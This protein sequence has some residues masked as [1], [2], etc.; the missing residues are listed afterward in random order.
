MGIS[1]QGRTGWASVPNAIG[2][3]RLP[4]PT[5]HLLLNLLTHS[6]GFDASY[7]ILT[8]QTG[9]GRATISSA[10]KN[11][12]KL[13]LVSVEKKPGKHGQFDS[14]NYVFHAD[15]LWTLTP[16][17]VDERLRKESTGS[18][19]ELGTGS[20][21]ELAPVQEL[22][23][24]KEQV[25]RPV[26][27]DQ[28]PS[29]HSDANASGESPDDDPDSTNQPEANSGSK[30]RIKDMQEFGDAY[31]SIAPVTKQMWGEL[32]RVWSTMHRG[33]EL[34]EQ[35]VLLE[36]LRGYYRA[37]KHNA[38]IAGREA[39]KRPANWLR[40]CMWL[41]TEDELK[42]AEPEKPESRP[43][44]KD[45]GYELLADMAGNALPSASTDVVEGE[46]VGGDINPS[47]D[48]SAPLFGGWRELS[49]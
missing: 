44:F 25:E 19:A 10:L 43:S 35:D 17:F 42:F 26:E 27:N 5:V 37:V 33:G 18:G 11:M 34:P 29:G 8:E 32:A 6:E 15:R 41:A 49:C 7:S 39:V 21:A 47:Q 30:N 46:V 48:H 38:R 14:N 2:R 16:E 22:N 20:G 40:D 31:K 12:K 1:I 4:H 28:P 9:M 13:D 45:V 23:R 3:S 24:K 36:S